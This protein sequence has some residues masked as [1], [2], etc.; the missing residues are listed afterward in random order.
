MIDREFIDLQ[1]V[2]AGEYSLERELGRGGMVYLAPEVHL[3]RCVA[4]AYG[5]CP[6]RTATASSIAT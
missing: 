3:D 1:E 4:G 2:L 6:T 5:L